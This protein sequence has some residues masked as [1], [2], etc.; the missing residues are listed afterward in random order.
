VVKPKAYEDVI[1]VLEK[2][3]EEEYDDHFYSSQY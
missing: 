2:S 3:V 1:I